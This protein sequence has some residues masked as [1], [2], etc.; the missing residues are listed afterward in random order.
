MNVCV[1]LHVPPSFRVFQ[2]ASALSCNKKNKTD[3]AAAFRCTKRQMKKDQV[4]KKG[5]R[6]AVLNERLSVLPDTQ[7]RLS[8]SQVSVYLLK[9]NISS[10][11]VF[12][13]ASA[14]ISTK[15]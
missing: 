9:S 12:L 15:S 10:A 1:L 8:T 2:N 6:L 14:T 11:L 13:L 5:V 3:K 7:H 4:K